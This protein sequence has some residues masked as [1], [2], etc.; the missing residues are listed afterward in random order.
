MYNATNT[1]T[2]DALLLI[3]GIPIAFVWLTAGIGMVNSGIEK[4]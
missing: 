4:M 2:L 1:D 3:F